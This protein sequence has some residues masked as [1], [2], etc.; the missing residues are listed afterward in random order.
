MYTYIYIYIYISFIIVL[1]KIQFIY[2]PL[3]FFYIF[4][5]FTNLKFTFRTFILLLTLEYKLLIL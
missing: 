3:L 1:L 5:N 2:E 4:Y